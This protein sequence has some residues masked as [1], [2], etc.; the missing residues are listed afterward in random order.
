[1]SLKD[2]YLNWTFRRPTAINTEGGVATPR[3]QAAGEVAV[4]FMSNEYQTEIRTRPFNDK[5]VLPATEDD[6]TS[7]TFTQS[8][9]F[10]YGQK[11]TDAVLT[12]YKGNKVHKFNAQG[13]GDNDK[14]ITSE[15]VKDTPGATYHNNP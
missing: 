13:T 5:T 12:M 7:G 11:V 3:E 4:D 1:M 15:K 14:Y 2:L 6:T 10:R 8:A 9:L